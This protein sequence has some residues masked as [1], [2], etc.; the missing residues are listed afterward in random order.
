MPRIH[1]PPSCLIRPSPPSCVVHSQVVVIIVGLHLERSRQYVNADEDGFDP[2]NGDVSML[3]LSIHRA[4]TGSTGKKAPLSPTSTSNASSPILGSTPGS[5]SPHTGSAL[6]L[7]GPG[8]TIDFGDD[9]DR[10]LGRAS[11]VPNDD[12]YY[13]MAM[14][15]S[16]V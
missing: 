1:S 4:I 12:P 11:K 14:S 10:D 5:S 16:A 2:Y 7:V 3:T 8:D 15:G 13:T 9:R 6:Q